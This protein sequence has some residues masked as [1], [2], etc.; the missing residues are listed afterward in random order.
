MVMQRQTNP[1]NLK[2][3]AKVA[4]AHQKHK[5]NPVDYGNSRLPEGIENGIAQL[6]AMGFAEHKDGENKGKPYFR[7]SGI[8]H[9]PVEHDGLKVAGMQTSI[10]I[11]MYD[12]PKR[13]KKQTFAD[14]W[15]DFLNLMKQFEVD[16]PP[17]RVSPTE[18]DEQ[19]GER[20]Q[21][22]FMSVCEILAGNPA[23]KVAGQQPFFKFRTWKGKKT[24]TG[25]YAN[26]E[27]MVQEEWQGKTEWN[28]SDQ[29]V[30]AVEE[31]QTM[32][33]EP[34]S[35]F[36]QPDATASPA[37]IP[38]SSSAPELSLEELAVAADADQEGKTP[39]GKEA[40]LAL[41]KMAR[42]VGISDEDISNAAS[43]TEIALTIEAATTG[44][45]TDNTPPPVSK[46]D[47]VKGAT[48]TYNGAQ[49]EVTSADPRHRTCT[50]RDLTTKKPVVGADKKLLKVS[51]DQ[52]S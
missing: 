16:M 20:I 51:W 11:P 33:P 32:G 29:T 9:S 30:A 23:K 44:E 50:L 47:P 40:I 18:T 26:K 8:V 10:I 31:G 46:P 36:A 25:P 35:E 38:S 41:T 52:L 37:A 1:L 6:T 45:V 39:Q 28:P 4:Q 34:F 2:L 3:G 19:A 24:T 22:Y 27:P 5:D 14:H 48:V 12:T 49:C 21:A 17:D 42:D 15:A 43:W 7:A 13:Q